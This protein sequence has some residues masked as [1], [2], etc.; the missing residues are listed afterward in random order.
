M[1]RRIRVSKYHA[2]PNSNRT[3][4]QHGK[5]GPRTSRRLFFS[6]FLATVERSRR[7]S[8]SPDA[9]SVATTQR[10]SGWILRVLKK[11]YMPVWDPFFPFLP[12]FIGPSAGS[13]DPRNL[14]QVDDL[15]ELEQY[16]PDCAM[17]SFWQ[18]EDP[19]DYA[20]GAPRLDDGK[21]LLRSY[22]ESTSELLE[23]CRFF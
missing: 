6:S 20:L 8:P 22:R 15:V 3:I 7:R 10:L 16:Y 17:D 11:Y 14:L 9:R 12:K 5:P 13:I 19:W 18:L 21:T 1:N 23:I 4:F 2:Q